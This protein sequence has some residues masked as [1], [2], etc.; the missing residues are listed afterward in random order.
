MYLQRRS[1]L[2]L[3]VVKLLRLMATVPVHERS[4]GV[5]AAIQQGIGFL[6]TYDLA[7]ADFPHMGATSPEWFRLGFPRG[8]QSDV[9]ETL[10][11]LARQ[12]QPPDPVWK[13]LW[14]WC[15]ASGGPTPIRRFCSLSRFLQI[16]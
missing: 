6:L 15:S 5:K 1:A 11:A 2:R 12:E 3:G 4:P 10:E 14:P 16:T 7:R 9:L 13:L 8:H